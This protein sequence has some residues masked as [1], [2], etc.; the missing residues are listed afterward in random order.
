[1]NAV[2]PAPYAM[3][4]AHTP[5]NSVVSADSLIQ[6]SCATGRTSTR[7]SSP[8]LRNLWKHAI[9]TGFTSDM[10]PPISPSGS[11]SAVNTL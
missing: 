2:P 4:S 3:P 10:R 1:M 5:V 8:S 11:D 9:C 7:I 6:P